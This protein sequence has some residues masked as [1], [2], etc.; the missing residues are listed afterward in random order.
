MY[1][2]YIAKQNVP[3]ADA[4]DIVCEVFE[5]LM[6]SSYWLAQCILKLDRPDELKNIL[7]AFLRNAC[8]NYHRRLN[9]KH[10]I[11][12]DTSESELLTISTD[13][14]QEYED[15][16]LFEH[17]INNTNKLSERGK[18]IIMKYHIKG[19]SADELAE[20]TGLSPRTIESYLYRTM[21][22]LRETLKK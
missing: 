13:V 22:L 17:I 14:E 8:N 4:E 9:I 11:F 6:K 2:L 12:K 19:Y 20:Q 7:R 15:R 1:L 3:E 10:Q 21:K 16:D 18:D 5:K